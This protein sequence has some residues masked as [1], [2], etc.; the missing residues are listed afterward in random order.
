[1]AR[2]TNINLIN[3]EPLYDITTFADLS[4][5]EVFKW[6][7]DSN[8]KIS[9]EYQVGVKTHSNKWLRFSDWVIVDIAGKLG[10]STV[11]RVRVVDVSVEPVLR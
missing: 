1:M 3:P 6:A 8:P 5:G 2:T 4:V 9:G 11:F 7:D 10:G